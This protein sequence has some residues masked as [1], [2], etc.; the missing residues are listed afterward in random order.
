[1]KRTLALPLLGGL[2]AAAHPAAHSVAVTFDDLPFADP[3]V[4]DAGTRA[5]AAN[6]QIQKMLRLYSAP[7]I[8]F[9]NETKIQSLGSAGIA[10]V[11]SWNRGS[12]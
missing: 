10:I 5:L 3:S 6:K 8:G 1:M 7:A 2:L 4:A 12:L 9:V 11:K